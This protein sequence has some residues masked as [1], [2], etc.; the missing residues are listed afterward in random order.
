MM[1]GIWTMG[2][3]AVIWILAFV[4]LV[5]AIAAPAKYLRT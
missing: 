5:L 3:M 2:G 4:A 1:G